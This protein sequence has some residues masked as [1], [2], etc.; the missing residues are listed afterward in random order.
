MGSKSFEE[1]LEA[2]LGDRKIHPWGKQLGMTRGTIQRLK[3]GDFPDPAKLMPACRVENLSLSWLLYGI[4]TPYLVH[5]AI[6]AGDAIDQVDALLADEPWDILIAATGSSWLPVLHKPAD[7]TLPNGTI[8]DYR[9]VHVISGNLKGA[10]TW[11]A[12]RLESTMTSTWSTLAMGGNEWRRL[13]GLLEPAFPQHRG[14]VG[15]ECAPLTIFMGHKFA[16]YEDFHGGGS[17]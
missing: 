1:R 4:G 8:L 6:D 2:V 5:V 10:E 15:P 12:D 17:L 16:D 9:L 14:G 3:E 7:V 11:V 13:A